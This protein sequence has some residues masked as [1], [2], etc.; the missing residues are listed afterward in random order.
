VG[1]RKQ[2]T[3]EPTAVAVAEPPAVDPNVLA[4]FRRILELD[5][6]ALVP[7]EL[8]AL[9]RRYRRRVDLCA[10]GDVQ[11][12]ELILLVTIYE[13]VGGELGEALLPPLDA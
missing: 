10:A 1:K 3:D 7:D 4:S 8:L 9:Y 2:R 13:H 12:K 6:E 11:T 5:P